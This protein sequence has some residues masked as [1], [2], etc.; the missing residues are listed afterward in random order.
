[1]EN[2]PFSMLRV[3]AIGGV[4][5]DDAS[6]QDRQ[7]WG[8]SAAETSQHRNAAQRRG[9]N[10]QLILRAVHYPSTDSHASYDAGN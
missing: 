3:R 1:M 7:G 9:V 10:Q 2:P 4:M 5:P 8:I 6:V